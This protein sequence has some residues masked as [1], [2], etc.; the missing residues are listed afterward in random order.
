[1]KVCKARCYLTTWGR[2]K[3][4]QVVFRVISGRKILFVFDM[5]HESFLL[6]KNKKKKMWKSFLERHQL[7]AGKWQGK[8]CGSEFFFVC[9]RMKKEETRGI[10]IR[11]RGYLRKKFQLCSR[12][13]SCNQLHF[14]RNSISW[15]RLKVFSNF[16]S[17]VSI[18]F[19]NNF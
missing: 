17:K 4:F 13:I 2:V 19:Q 5:R 3:C 18:R 6:N 15:N 16:T 12:E 1:M 11:F 7:W 10:F 8:M 14:M 9:I